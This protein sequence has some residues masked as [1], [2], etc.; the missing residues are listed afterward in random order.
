M[1]RW[2]G[3]GAWLFNDGW[4]FTK[5][6]L[7]SSREEALAA[8]WK[9]VQL[10]HDW[11]IWQ[12]GDLYESADAWYRRRIAGEDI[13]AETVLLCFDGVYMDCDVLLNGKVLC[14][15]PYGYTAFQVDLSGELQPG[16]NEILVHI[17]HQ[18]P[19]TRWYSGSGI[20][21]EVTLRKLP[22]S[23]I[24]PDSLCTFTEQ[25]ALGWTLR[26]EMETAG[27]GEVFGLLRDPEG[28]ELGS[29]S[30]FAR[31][32]K[33]ALCWEIPGGE[34]WSPAHPALYTLEY[35][36]GSQRERTRIGLRTLRF[37]PESGFWINGENIK[38]KGVC[39]HH[40]LGALGAAF[41]VKAARRQLRIM[42]EMGVN[43][44]RTSH[45]PPA[46]QML[47]LCDEMG[48]LVVDEILDMWERPKTTYDYARFFP[49]HEVE[50]V[51]SWVRRDRNHAS[52]IMWSIGNEIY[53]MFADDRGRE[54]ACLLR[55][56]VRAHDPAGHGAVTFGSN[57]MPWEGAQRCAEEIKIPGY[58]YAE[59]FYDAHHAAHP[60]W[61]IYGSETA[62]VLSSRGI[63]HFPLAKNIL[64]DAD[65]QCS[66]LGN[67]TSSWG[68][69]D[70]KKMIVED[71][72][73]PYSMGQFV[74]SGID[75]IGEP[76][77]YHTRSCYF[78]QVDTA[79]FPKDAFYLFQSLWTEEPM[80]HIGVSWDWNAGQM[81][82]VPV[83]SSCDQVELF[84]NGQSLG[85]QTLEKRNPEKCIGCWRLPFEKGE[86]RAVGYDRDGKVICQDAR[87]TSG[88][89]AA[90]RLTAEDDRLL[91]DGQDMTFVTVEALD[92]AGNLVANARDRL[93]VEVSGGGILLGL[94]NGDASDTD[95]Y[96]GATKRLFGGKALIMVGSN[97]K[98]EPVRIAVRT[99]SGV[100]AE[101]ELGVE[102]P[103][104]EVLS[105]TLQE[106]PAAT[107]AR[108]IPVRRVEIIAKDSCHLTPENLEARF[109]WKVW[110]ENADPVEIAWQVTNETGILS[111][112]AEVMLEEDQ[113]RVV[114]RGDGKVM[115][116]ALYGNAVDHHPEQ[117]SQ[118]ELE[119]SGL[120][121][122]ELDPYQMITAGLHDLSDGDIG[123]GNEQGIAFARDSG[124]S[125][126][127]FRQ[128]NFGPAG[129]DRII[130]SIFTLDGNPYDIW[131]YDGDPRE[132][133][134]LIDTLRYQKPSIWNVYQEESYTLPERLCGVHT[135][136]FIAEKKFHFKGF[137][138]EK[139]SRAFSWQ[140][141]GQ[142]DA[143]YGDSFRR[144]GD[145]VFDIGNNVSLTWE[146][147]D[148][149]DLREAGIVIEGRT[150]LEMNA[151]TLRMENEAGESRTEVVKFRG[152][153]QGQQS[154]RVAV[155][156]GNTKV[157][158]VF[159][160]GS[161]F[162]FVGFTFEV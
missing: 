89:T 154:F 49:E 86:L 125:M 112:C 61:V 134:R 161:Q 90:L 24:R 76:T 88:D 57:Y 13:Q 14:S 21:R 149:G 30:A 152:G 65:L 160:P 146:N 94:D 156:G 92:G 55:D 25:T 15:H 118:M 140:Q 50:D 102:R 58:N 77:P 35:G 32:G 126:V 139:Q 128:V 138:F 98:A 91:A 80:I 123:A 37:D 83:M 48:I 113:V 56:Q 99:T 84:L 72:N 26:A 70:L 63:Y 119:I 40:D 4:E 144:E 101:L 69:Q 115:L 151:I 33:A 150:P 28:K 29:V 36:M 159:L 42:Q 39:L 158:F 75:Y 5:L 148:F 22:A 105:I 8:E 38:M 43:A 67:S 127:G 68:A 135:L 162:D 131:M 51:A 16:E 95:E 85:V 66:A 108:E 87:I 44:L 142:A 7:G 78:G 81:I 73:N 60:D 6:P 145:A 9:R 96:K 10:P 97:G 147:M 107:E 106:I 124:D 41:H 47:D 116:R 64:S 11:L 46:R 71:L 20:Y 74:W 45:N 122:V 110:P 27:E 143:L 52:V 2:E 100:T 137:Y 31:E 23:Y 129:S 141:A 109:S 155:P 34:A 59:K 130:L 121:S 132:G 53:D 62:S 93:L 133:G 18:S 19:N 120:G 1:D 157:S 3:Y 54:V 153:D 114:A 111:P 136:C 12:A 17:R 103:A 82:D 117:I 104:G 79:G